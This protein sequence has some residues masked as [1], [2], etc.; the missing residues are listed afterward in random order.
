VLG[1]WICENIAAAIS[2][3]LNKE[4]TS[5]AVFNLGDPVA[6]SEAR[7]VEHIAGMAGWQGK[8][9]I[10]PDD[11]LPDPLKVPFN[12]TQNWTIDASRF[13][14]ETGFA[15]PFTLEESLAETTAWLREN[16]PSVSAEQVERWQREDEA[17]DR[18]LAGT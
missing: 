1:T 7:W 5:S 17:E 13:R 2:H 15:E 6:L 9:V 16:P 10:V 11:Q 4:S 12:A 18:W 14:S 3:C 8:I